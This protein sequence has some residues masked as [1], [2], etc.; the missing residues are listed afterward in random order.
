MDARS[1]VFVRHIS[2][3]EG[4]PKVCGCAGFDCASVVSWRVVTLFN[5]CVFIKGFSEF[6]GSQ[7][8]FEAVLASVLLQGLLKH[9]QRQTQRFC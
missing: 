6:A 9:V 8:R 3:C 7:L 2:V 5:L 4:S 1:D